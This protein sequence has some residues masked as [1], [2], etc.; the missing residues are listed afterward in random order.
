M[1]HFWIILRGAVNSVC[2]MALIFSMSCFKYPIKTV[3]LAFG[4]LVLTACAVNVGFYYWLGDQAMKQLFA[5]TVAV[6]SV[7]LL[8]FLTKDRTSH[9]FFNFFTAINA[10]YLVSI[11]SRMTMGMQEVVWVDVLLR[12]ALYGGIL[13]V[14]H[15]FFNHPYRFL[16]DNMKWGWSVISAIPFLFF[17]IVMFLGLYPTVRSD[18]FPAVLM[19]YGVLCCVYVVIYQAFRSAYD[20]LFQRQSQQ[21][22]ETQLAAQKQYEKT[23]LENEEWIRRI[24]HDI[25]GHLRLLSNLLSEGKFDEASQ[26]LAEVIQYNNS[27]QKQIYCPN[28]YL[29]AVLTDYAARFAQENAN[30]NCRI[31][32]GNQPLPAVELCLILN[33]ALENAL[34]ASLRLPAEERTVDIQAQ[35]RQSQFLLRIRNRFDGVLQEGVE[36]PASRKGALGHG[37]GLSTIA[38]AAQ[39]LEGSASYRAEDGWFTLDVMATIPAPQ[40]TVGAARSVNRS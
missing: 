6:P 22:L 11:L 40:E 34:E 33:N 21:T 7:I 23:L 30:F 27:T 12:S 16:T 10:L 38:A 32:I 1:S 18:N 15:R 39:R 2:P 17:C 9:L 8:L 28:P 25:Q 31:Q 24:R 19:L 4:G 13:Y 36:W 35:I 3:R 5:V 14:F 26:Y 37:Y 29:N 20:L